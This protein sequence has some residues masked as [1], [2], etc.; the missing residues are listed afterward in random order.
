MGLLLDTA[1]QEALKLLDVFRVDDERERFNEAHRFLAACVRHHAAT[2]L[3]PNYDELVE[4]A[5]SQLFGREVRMW[6][7]DRAEAGRGGICKLHGTVS[8]PDSIRIS[9]SHIG[10]RLEEG[11]ADS[12]TRCI[13]S[14]HGCFVGWAAADIDIVPVVEAALIEARRRGQSWFF[15]LYPDQDCRT[16]DEYRHRHPEAFAFFERLQLPVILVRS[17]CLFPA[18]NARL[19]S[20]SAGT[21]QK[22]VDLKWPAD[23]VTEVV[24]RLVAACPF[25]PGKVAGRAL[26]L[27]EDYSRSD[28]MYA[29][30]LANVEAPPNARAQMLLERSHAAFD[31]GQRVA[32]L[33]FA[34]EA[35]RLGD[36][37]RDQALW[38]VVTQLLALNWWD[39]LRQNPNWASIRSLGL[40][41]ARLPIRLV[42]LHASY[43]AAAVSPQDTV[44]HQGRTQLFALRTWEVAALTKV[45][46]PLLRSEAGFRLRRVL[47]ARV[48]Q[49]VAE[50]AELKELDHY[51]ADLR[52]FARLRRWGNPHEALASLTEARRFCQGI[53][54]RLAMT[55]L[56]RDIAA[57][58]ETTLETTL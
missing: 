39:E 11:L 8:V 34:E 27:L 24:L 47:E 13:V 5:H 46:A 45:L 40:Q 4:T 54:A 18:L 53:H 12:V 37:V 22:R 7:G 48:L 55:L 26:H 25:L 21:F 2:V 19:F 56:D 15:L 58:S 3:T 33:S 43:G 20:M 44:R 30:T 32:A 29:L 41:L 17:E 57:I 36:E 28:Q 31:A 23:L 38:G 50:H 10:A 9:F 42:R 16:V 6:A 52:S 35:A 51:Y 49:S 1:G 14:S